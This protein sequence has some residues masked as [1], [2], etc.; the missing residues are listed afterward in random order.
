VTTLLATA[1]LAGCAVGYQARGT[2]SDVPG[3]LRGKGYPGGGGGG[4]VVL[5]DADGHLICDGQ[6]EPANRSPT[7]GTCAGES[8]E[9]VI[10]CSDG[11]E[12][13]MRW[14]A[15]SCRAWKGGGTD[16]KG[17]RLEFRVERR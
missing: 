15:I 10:R 5:S 1:L 14:E 8:G 11:R 16:A 4:R 9:G 17:N 2:L 3:E 6:A 12:L 7:P 13:A